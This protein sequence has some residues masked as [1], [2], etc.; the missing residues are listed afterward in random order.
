[1]NKNTQVLNQGDLQDEDQEQKGEC[2]DLVSTTKE[3]SRL[4][5]DW[6]STMIL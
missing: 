3:E 1:M 4:E 2:D 6:D 5:C